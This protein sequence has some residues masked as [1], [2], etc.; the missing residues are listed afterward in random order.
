MSLNR[1]TSLESW[2][3]HPSSY[4]HRERPNQEHPD[5][6]VSPE[7]GESNDSI[8]DS[9]PAFASVVSE[10]SQNTVRRKLSF[11]PAAGPSWTHACVNDEGEDQECRR[12][13]RS[14]SDGD[15]AVIPSDAGLEPDTLA[16][17]EVPKWKRVVQVCVA[18]V[19]CVLSAG[20]VFGYAALKPLLIEEGSSITKFFAF[21]NVI[22][23]SPDIRLNF[24]FTLAAVATNICALP[25]G[26]VLDFFGPR[27]TGSI[28]SIFIASGSLCLALASILPFDTYISGYSLLAIGGPF[29]FISAFQLSNTFP[30]HSGLILAML[31]GAFDSSSAVFLLFRIVHGGFLSLR[32]LFLLYLIV[33]SFVLL[34]QM[35]LMPSTSY[36]TAGELIQQAK[37]VMAENTADN[38]SEEGVPTSPE[39]ERQLENREAERRNIIS[40]IQELLSAEEQSNVPASPSDIAHPPKPSKEARKPDCIW[41]VLHMASALQQIQSPYFIFMAFFTVLQMLR[42]NYFIAT[43]NI[44]YEYLL[45]SPQ[46][47]K[48]LN[49]IFDIFLPMAGIVAIPFIGLILDRTSSITILATLVGCSTLIGILGCIPNSLPAA[50][51]NITLF[52]LYRPFYYSSI[53]DFA[54]KV[55][56]FQTFGK[57]YG[58]MICLA[59]VG[60]FLQV[61]LDVLTLRLFRRNPTPVNILLTIVTSVAGALLVL[62]V[63]WQARERMAVVDVVIENGGVG[64][65]YGARVP[66]N[67]SLRKRW[68]RRELRNHVHYH[69]DRGGER[70]ERERLITGSRQDGVNDSARMY[71]ALS[72]G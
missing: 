35:L 18:V 22:L 54:A 33:P 34:S 58:L 67:S 72:G 6:Y 70:D 19:Y 31:T 2:E 62:F 24:M 30:A 48:Q 29:V 16:A 64:Q 43:I 65:S 36:K 10:V 50:Y 12:S 46:L 44:Q 41:G 11:N 69:D 5:G 60:N 3:Y 66:N 15:S 21:Q 23:S 68:S 7:E 8:L 27:F 14:I 45:S 51:A 63:G 9:A 13:Q 52:T 25:V 40:N 32:N 55:F 71:G 37:N 38:R 26:A 28:G 42:V 20:V 47:A 56:G 61:P 49:A 1:V 59:G 57:V 17:Y 4:L 53:S 39:E